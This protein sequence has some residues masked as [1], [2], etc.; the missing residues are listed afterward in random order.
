[1]TSHPIHQTASPMT[2]PTAMKTSYDVFPNFR[3]QCQIL[4]G[5]STSTARKTSQKPFQTSLRVKSRK[6]DATATKSVWRNE[7]IRS[8]TD[9]RECPNAVRPCQSHCVVIVNAAGIFNVNNNQQYLTKSLL[10][11]GRDF[12][13]N[14]HE[15]FTKSAAALFAHFKVF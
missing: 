4:I 11:R 2:P 6:K 13:M 15:H 12:V 3:T 14:L 10:K 5:K 7:V 1:M 9:E 8:A